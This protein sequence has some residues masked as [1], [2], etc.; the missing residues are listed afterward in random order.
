MPRT[1][2][3]KRVCKRGALLCSGC[4]K[5]G[6]QAFAS[7]IGTQLA[8][9]LGVDEPQHSRIRELLLTRILDLDG[10]HLVPARELEQGAAPVLRPTEVADHDHDGALLRQGTGPAER[11][12]ERSDPAALGRR[13]VP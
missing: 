3:R 2:G 1:G 9:G 13:L 11:F 12:A 10:H 6:T 8:A 4:R 5:P 7:G